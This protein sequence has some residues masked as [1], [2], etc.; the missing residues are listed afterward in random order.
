MPTL[1][2]C[3]PTLNRGSVI[4]ET[5]ATIVRQADPAEVELVIVDGGSTDDT[6]AVVAGFQRDFPSLRYVRANA[7]EEAAGAPKPSNAGFDRD[8]SLA[9][10]LARGSYCWLLSDD[11]L[12]KEG[13][14]ARV[15]AA[16]REGW[17]LVVV[18]AE[19]RNADFSAVVTPSQLSFTEDRAYEPTR[20]GRNRFMAEVGPYLS[21]LGGV[22]IR[23]DEWMS[24]DRERYF[25]SG[26]VHVGVIFQRPFTAPVCAIG[27]PLVMIRYGTGAWGSRGFE[28]WAVRWAE[29][30]WSF[31]DYDAAAKGAVTRERPWGRPSILLLYRAKGW[32][33]TKEYRAFVRPRLTSARDRLVAGAIA[34]LPARATNRLMAAYL[35]HRRPELRVA[36]AD[37]ENA[38]R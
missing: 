13:A 37:V 6:A 25:G 16:I 29:L 12:L 27:E 10:E 21:F 36:L 2:I 22:V 4:G 9:V 35:R 30:I 1:S 17:A 24:R 5:L 11:D 20:E 7:A 19:V 32:Y 14:V 15:L 33:S 23:R 3:I 26:F 18:N 31:A 34:R 38:R 8:C 28:I